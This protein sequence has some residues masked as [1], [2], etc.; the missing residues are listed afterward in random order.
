[1]SP[2]DS[3]IYINTQAI[4]GFQFSFEGGI[5]SYVKLESIAKWLN[6]RIQW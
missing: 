1:M 6:T 4:L 3:E 5:L 2:V